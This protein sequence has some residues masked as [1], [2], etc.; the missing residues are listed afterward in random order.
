MALAAPRV[1]PGHRTA[2]TEGINAS[3][4]AEPLEPIR[5]CAAGLSP[6]R[7]RGAGFRFRSPADL[8]RQSRRACR[9]PIWL[10]AGSALPL[11]IAERV[12]GTRVQ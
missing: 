1:D 3:T 11:L 2:M 7:P 6:L 8:K 5:R 12:R 10:R 4:A 9:R